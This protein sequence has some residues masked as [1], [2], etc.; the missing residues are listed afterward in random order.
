MPQTKKN[1]KNKIVLAALK[2]LARQGW[3]KLTLDQ[4]ARAAKISLAQVK[5]D[6]HDGDDLIA[7]IA[8]YVGAEALVTVGKLDKNASV[9]DRLFEI[10]MARFDVLQQHRAAFLKIMDAMQ[11]NP[12]LLRRF[13]P[14]Q[15]E[16][17]KA[18]LRFA[19]A[20]QKKSHEAF[21]IAGLS[22]IYALTLCV[23]RNDN[24]ADLSR[25]MAALDR[26]L[27]RAG[28]G[29]EILFRSLP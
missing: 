5:K 17:M 4:V 18:M 23:W 16:A 14:V 27:R 21:S 22:G 15:F 25:T 13:L 10:M 12:S 28:M 26:Y 29:A 11:R 8:Q 24:S 19:G 20:T 3:D 6:F 1:S 9:K 7:A 2:I